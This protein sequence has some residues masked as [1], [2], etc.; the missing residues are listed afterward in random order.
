MLGIATKQ[1]QVPSAISLRS[2]L[3]SFKDQNSSQSSIPQDQRSSFSSRK[4]SMKIGRILLT[5]NSKTEMNLRKTQTISSRKDKLNKYR[6]YP[7]P[8][9]Y[10]VPSGTV[11]VGEHTGMRGRK[12]KRSLN[13]FNTL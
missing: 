10:R 7:T 4:D 2:Y 3:H 9:L 12:Y 1:N 13:G 6:K 11:L 8:G 5:S